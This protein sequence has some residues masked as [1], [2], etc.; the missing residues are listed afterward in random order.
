MSG[1]GNNAAH[2]GGRDPPRKVAE[3]AGALARAE[4]MAGMS[5]KQ[6]V[7]LEREAEARPS[8]GRRSHFHNSLSVPYKINR[9]A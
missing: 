9:L 1:T 2:R 5:A 8:P 6:A 3:L 7:Q 4:E